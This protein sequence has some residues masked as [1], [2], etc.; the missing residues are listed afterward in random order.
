MPSKLIT[1]DPQKFEQLC[2]ALLHAEY[3]GFV[4]LS[5]PDSGADGV[6]DDSSTVFQVYFPERNPRRDKI[7]GDLAKARAQKC[8]RKHFVF[9]LPKNPTPALLDFLKKKQQALSFTI[10]V[11]GQTHIEA[12]L[13][14]HQRIRDDYFPS[15]L[16]RV[17]KRLARGKRPASGDAPPGA[18]LNPE[19]AAEIRQLIIELAEEEATRKK[20]RAK[21]HDYRG[22]FGEFNSHFKLSVYGRLPRTEVPAARQYLEQKRY[23]RRGNENAS[24]TRHRCVAGI[25]AIQRHLHMPD[26][27]YRR[28]LVEFGGSSSTTRMDTRALQRVFEHFK[29]LQGAAA[30]AS[31]AVPANE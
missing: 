19:E 31:S 25:K 1:L 22:E 11:W 5:A 7:A 18:E 6:D 2:Q 21:K 28:L 30:V 23:G 13:R 3:P 15:E 12:L 4:A 29:H 14:K 20:R 24:A 8:P 17:V 27:A 10:D 26:E 9:L 16:G